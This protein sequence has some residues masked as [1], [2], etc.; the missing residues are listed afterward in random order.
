MFADIF[1]AY[2]YADFHTQ[3]T[4]FKKVQFMKIK[5]IVSRI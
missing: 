4:Y 3:R 1:H 5:E 2:M